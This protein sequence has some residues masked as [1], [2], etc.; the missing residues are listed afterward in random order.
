V[1]DHLLQAA[2][3]MN[4]VIAIVGVVLGTVIGALPGLSATMAVAVV[5]G[6]TRFT[7]DQPLRVR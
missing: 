4:V 3:P 6:D 2:T 1:I 7:L 5:G